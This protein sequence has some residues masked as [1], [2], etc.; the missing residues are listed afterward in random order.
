MNNVYKLHCCIIKTCKQNDPRSLRSL[1]LSCAAA[2]PESL[3]YAR[4]VFSRIPSPDTFAYNTIIRAHSHYFPSHS[5]SCFSSMRCNGVPCDHFTFPFVLKACSRLQMDLHLHSL[6][7]K[8]GLD[9]DIFVQN[10]LMSVYGCCGSVEIAVKVF[11]EMSERDSV[12]WSTVIVSFVNNGYASEA[13]ALFKAMQLEDKVV[14]DEVTMLSVISAISHLGALELGRWVRMFIDKLGLEISV[15][16]GTALIDMFSRCGSIDESVVVFE[17]MAVRNVLTW[18]ALINGFAVHGRSREALAVFH[19][20]RNSGV[21]PDYIT[22]SSVLVAC[23][24]GGL[25]R[26]GRDIF[27][28]ISKDYKMVPYL[29]HYGCMVDLLGRAGL[30]NEAYEFVERMPMKPNSIIWRTLLGACANHNDLDIAEKVKAKISE[31]NSS[32]DGDFVLLSNVYGAAGR[33]VEKT[34]VRSWMRSKRIGKEPG[35]SLINID[36]ATHEFVSGDDSHPQSEEITKFLSLIIGNLRNSGYTPRTENV[37]HDIDEEEREHS[38]SY[39]SEKLAV[40]FALLSLKDKR[41]IRVMKNLRICHD[42]HSFMKHISDRYE[43]KII[44]RDRN[45]FHHFDKGSCSCHDYW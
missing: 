42:C 17:E 14:P 29:E 27:E 13:L 37:L 7:V 9:S 33:W 23:S 2:A 16:L 1:L 30:L 24:H 18:T 44:I 26:E 43:R 22:F 20:M 11:D 6:I 3:S 19:S 5:L 40:A 32:H 45:R 39:H 4:Y 10:S 36:Q 28:S 34:S 41:T 38:L 8:Y 12:S 21:Q 25:V 35:C 31:L 15:A